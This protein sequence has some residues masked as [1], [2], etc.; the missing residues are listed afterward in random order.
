MLCQFINGV[1]QGVFGFGNGFLLQPAG[2]DAAGKIRKPSTEGAL[3]TA[4]Q[5]R[6]RI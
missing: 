3:R 4:L 1:R 6:H 5:H 2:R